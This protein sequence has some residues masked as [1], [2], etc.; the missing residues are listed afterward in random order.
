[1]KEKLQKQIDDFKSVMDTLPVNTIQNRN[2]KKNYIE[3]EKNNQNKVLENI[4]NEIN[5]RK[6]HLE[7]FQENSNIHKLQEDLKKCNIMQEWNKYNTPY[8]KMH[9]DYYLYQLHRYYKEDLKSVN[10]C[11]MTIISSFSKV[12]I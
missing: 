10:T 5:M 3:T 9:L 8:E 7:S 12:G 6:K 2:K 4:K 11:I 1:M